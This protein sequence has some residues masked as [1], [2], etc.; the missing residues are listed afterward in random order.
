MN[1]PQLR[2]KIDQVDEK[3]LKLLGERASLADEVGRIKAKSGQQVFA[4]EREEMLLRRLEK[5]NNGGLLS[6]DALRAIYREILSACRLRQKQIRVAY[7]GPTATNCHEAAL[8]RFGSSDL[9]QAYRTIPDVFAAVSREEAD[10]G[11]VPIENSTEGGVN[12]THDSLI[13][14]DLLICGEIYLRIAHHLVSKTA[15]G[16]IQ[17]IYSH[18]QAIGQCRNWLL[19]HYPETEIIESSSTAEGA[20][21][22][23]KEKGAASIS[24]AFAAEHYGLKIR[25]RNIQDASRNLTRF[26]ILSKHPIPPTGKDK[27]SLLFSVPHESGALSKVLDLFASRKLSLLKIE[28]RPAPLKAWEYFF[29][30]DVAG[31]AESP[32]VKTALQ[33]VQKDTIMMKILGSYPQAKSDV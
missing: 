26:L 4:P 21:L 31:H 19:R 3:L 5:M 27:T 22:A 18:P 13:Q 10:A 25:H 15:S 28:S 12:A 20:R 29:F 17:R 6:G 9:Y 32:S 33:S 30:V 24:S 1:L 7:F 23:K 8:A 2:S 16:P 11:V 14:T